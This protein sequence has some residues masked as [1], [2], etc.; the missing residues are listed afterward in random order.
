M[1]QAVT[2]ELTAALERYRA[3]AASGLVMDATTGEIFA[4]VSLPGVD[5]NKP[6]TALET[7]RVDRLHAGVFELGSI[8]K[9]LTIANALDRKSVV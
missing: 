4:A 1:Q 5:P 6:A 7:N 9:T 3:K 8:F 2:D